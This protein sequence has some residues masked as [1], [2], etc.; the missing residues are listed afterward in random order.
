MFREQQLHGKLLLIGDVF[1]LPDLGDAARGNTVHKLILVDLVLIFVVGHQ[2]V[3]IAART[4]TRLALTEL[5][6]SI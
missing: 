5:A 2:T 3:P 6:T 1:D 4:N